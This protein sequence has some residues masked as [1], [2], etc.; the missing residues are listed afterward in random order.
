MNQTVGERTQK[1][2][3]LTAPVFVEGKV[4]PGIGGGVSQVTGTLFN[5]ALLA[6]LP[7]EQYQTHDRPVHYLPV[8]RDATVA[9]G[10]LDMKFKNNTSAPIYISYK[11]SGG[12]LVATLYGARVSGERVALSV[13]AKQVGPRHVTAELYRTIKK[14]GK[15]EKKERV[16]RSDYTWKPNNPD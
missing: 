16:G 3:Y 4:V 5:A 9:W 2:G 6:G 12:R 8:G 14:N 1:R 13:Q 7:I 15:V 11:V 10:L